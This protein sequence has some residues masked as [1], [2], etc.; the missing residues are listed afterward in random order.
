[1]LSHTI[2]VSSDQKQT[3]QRSRLS[4]RESP[5]ISKSLTQEGEDDLSQLLSS[6]HDRN[7]I[8]RS[9]D[10]AASIE[11]AAVASPVAAK[12]F[13]S[14]LT[15]GGWGFT[16][17]R[18]NQEIRTAPIEK[19]QKPK[20]KPVATDDEPNMALLPSGAAKEKVLFNN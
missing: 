15:G 17:S 10:R 6:S 2:Q 18:A 19:Q 1:M 9:R 7:K 13:S 8:E 5:V 16:Q 14:P 11:A 4:S 20:E 3:G 12:D